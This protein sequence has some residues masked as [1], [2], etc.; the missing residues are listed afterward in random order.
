MVKR[1]VAAGNTNSIVSH[2]ALHMQW[3]KEVQRTHANWQGP[4]DYSVLCSYQFTS[5]CFEEDMT[6]AVR[7]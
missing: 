2:P 6:I 5:D 1:Y 7:L 4:I 3:I